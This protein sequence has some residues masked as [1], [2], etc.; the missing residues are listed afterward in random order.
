MKLVPFALER[1]FAEYEFA[2]PYL[3]CASDCESMSISELLAHEPDAEKQL[4]T[5]WLGYTESLGHPAL[6]QASATRQKA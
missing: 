4:S 5:L 3:L 1:Y 6:R 2:A